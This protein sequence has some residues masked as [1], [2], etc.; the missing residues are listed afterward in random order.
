MATASS[1]ST[2]SSITSSRPVRISGVWLNPGRYGLCGKP[3]SSSTSVYLDCLCLPRLPPS[4]GNRRWPPS[5]MHG[6]LRCA[7]A[8]AR[9]RFVTVDSL[10]T[11]WLT[12]P[13]A[14]R[15]NAGAR[16]TGCPRCGCG[17][18]GG[19]GG[20]GSRT[21]LCDVGERPRLDRCLGDAGSGGSSAEQVAPLGMI[22]ATCDG[23]VGFGCRC[24]NWPT[25]SLRGGPLLQRTGTPSRLTTSCCAAIWAVMARRTAT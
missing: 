11:A 3:R 2:M 8:T 1:A 9:G 13:V 16:G 6:G 18:E 10:I 12:P 21:G 17:G 15:V 25:T 23:A 4:A 22:K 5:C 24:V 7:E 20:L 19:L 14:L